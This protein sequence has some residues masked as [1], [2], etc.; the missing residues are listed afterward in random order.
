MNACTESLYKL[1]TGFITASGDGHSRHTS[2]YWQLELHQ[3]GFMV[4]L[5]VGISAD[6]DNVG[7]Y[8]VIR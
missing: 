1:L 6:L 5:S 8:E 3:G 2:C 7:P 4:P